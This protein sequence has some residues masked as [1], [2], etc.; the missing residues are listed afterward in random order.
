M[1]IKQHDYWCVQVCFGVPYLLVEFVGL[2]GYTNKRHACVVVMPFNQHVGMPHLSGG[3]II[4]LTYLDLNKSVKF[5]IN[6]LCAEK[7]SI[8]STAHEMEHK[9]LGNG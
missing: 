5:E 1:L 3:W 9:V 6:L 8:F 7:K 2:S 4:L